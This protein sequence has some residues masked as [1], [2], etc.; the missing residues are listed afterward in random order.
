MISVNS[1]FFQTGRIYPILPH[2]SVYMSSPLLVAHGPRRSIG[3]APHPGLIYCRH[4]CRL[5][6]IRGGIG[7][8]LDSIFSEQKYLWED[9]SL[10]KILQNR[11]LKGWIIIKNCDKWRDSLGWGRGISL[12]LYGFVLN[13]LLFDDERDHKYG[14]FLNLLI[15]SYSYLT[16]LC[17]NELYKW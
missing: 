16:R 15:R 14:N 1:A 9:M 3:W 2:T 7:R 17:Q 6:A 5:N 8:V 4:Q 10:R 12:H 13:F 11:M